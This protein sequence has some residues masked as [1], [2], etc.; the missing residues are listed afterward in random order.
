MDA[1]VKCDK[2][3]ILRV[4]PNN[5]HLFHDFYEK[6]LPLLEYSVCNDIGNILSLV[7]SGNIFVYMCLTD[8]VVSCY[9]FRKSCTKIEGK[10][11]LILYAS[12]KADIEIDNFIHLFKCSLSDLMKTEKEYVYLCV[13]ELGYNIEISEN[14][15]A[16]TYPT[17]IIHC[18]YFFYNYIHKTV[19]ANKCFILN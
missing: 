19:P 1:E 6:N 9:F 14:L 15:K 12:L 5:I 4:T 2:Y 3:K 8:E 17:D 11:I 13:E 10:E 7:K 16:K 18:S